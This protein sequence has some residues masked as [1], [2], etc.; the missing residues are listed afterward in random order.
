M[1]Q[2]QF[3]FSYRFIAST[4]KKE[5]QEAKTSVQNSKNKIKSHILLVVSQRS[6]HETNKA[7]SKPQN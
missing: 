1:I 7:N 5:N 6:N 2:A 4:M 3:S